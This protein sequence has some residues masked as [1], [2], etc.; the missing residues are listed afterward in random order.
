MYRVTIYES[1][2]FLI[3]GEVIRGLIDIRESFDV[4]RGKR[5]AKEFRK[6]ENLLV[7]G[8]NRKLKPG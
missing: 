2:Y 4:K 1:L 5:I 8:S 7:S 6:G 3:S